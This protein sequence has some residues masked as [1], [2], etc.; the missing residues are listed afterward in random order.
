MYFN[1]AIL[2]FGLS[3]LISSHSNAQT[4]FVK[5]KKYLI[6]INSYE[7]CEK[8]KVIISSDIRSTRLDDDDREDD[9]IQAL[10]HY[11][12]SSY[13]FETVGIISSPTGGKG[14][15]KV[16]DWVIDNYEKDWNSLNSTGKNYPSAQ[17]LRNVVVQGHTKPHQMPDLDS[18]QPT[19]DY[20]QTEK[21]NSQNPDHR[22]AKLIRD[23]VAK[24]INGEE[25]GPIYMLTWGGVSDLAVALNGNDATEPYTNNQIAKHLRVF[26]IGWSNTPSALSNPRS[27]YWNYLSA[28][29]LTNNQNNL[30]LIHSNETFRGVYINTNKNML[31]KLFGKLKSYGCLGNSV[32]SKTNIKLREPTGSFI[33]MG[34]SSSVLYL[35]DGDPTKPTEPSW[36]GKYRKTQYSNY[37]TDLTN[38][39]SARATITPLGTINSDG[40]ATPAGSIYGAWYEDM[41]HAAG[42]GCISP[43]PP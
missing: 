28:Q 18:E 2:L 4:Q 14:K 41:R 9:D 15:K 27:R 43:P 22:G 26:S 7:T 8:P 30:W 23:E 36:G 40:S 5:Y 3:L 29:Y 34:D 13:R 19:G 32:L 35:M 21:Y 31:D 11:L 12:V 17:S 37:W 10:V 39:V 25:C 20:R 33:K 1:K 42:N 38:Y 24:I 16:I 6:P